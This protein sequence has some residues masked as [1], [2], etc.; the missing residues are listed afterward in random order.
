MQLCARLQ[1]RPIVA[2][3][4]L[5]ILPGPLIYLRVMRRLFFFSMIEEQSDDF[6]GEVVAQFFSHER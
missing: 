2:G 5:H 3:K 6:T 1:E 4:E